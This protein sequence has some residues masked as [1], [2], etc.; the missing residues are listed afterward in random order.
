MA[1]ATTT[2]LTAYLAAG[3]VPTDAARLLDRATEAV[4]EVTLGNAR[5]AWDGLLSGINRTIPT[6]IAPYTQA[7]YQAAL[8]KATCAQVEYWL[9][10]GEEHDT[11][12]L[13]GS[14]AAGKVSISE[15]P[16]VLGRRAIR[17]LRDVNL[18][19]GAVAIG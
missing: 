17:A 13:R 18:V 12:S 4:D 3:T 19:G 15:L 7:E 1:Y 16:P 10:V 11:A 2:E 8:S 9:E 6:Q 5:L 14:A